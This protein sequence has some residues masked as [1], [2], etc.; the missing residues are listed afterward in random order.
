M[1]EADLPDTGATGRTRAYAH[2]VDGRPPA[3]WHDLREHLDAV[4]ARAGRFADAFG[5]GEWGRLAGLWHDLGKYR[6][7]FQAYL[8]GHGS[9]GDHAVAGA[10]LAERSKR[11]GDGWLPLAFAIAGHHVGL[12]DLRP[13]DDGSPPTPLVDRLAEKRSTLDEAVARA[14]ADLVAA[15]LPELPPRFRTGRRSDP[16]A[17]HRSLRALALWIRFVF[18][19]LVDADFLDTERF[20]RGGERAGHTGGFAAVP[21]LRQRLDRHLDALAARAPASEVNRVRAEVLAAARAAAEREPG[22]FSM[23]V[24]TG[25]GKTLASMS[26][27]LR[28]A[29]RH[30]LRRV[31]V[32]IPL[33][34]IIEQSAAV[35]RRALGDDQVI[36]HHSNLDPAKE[37]RR[38]KLASENWD[39]PVIVTTAVQL[40]ESLFANRTSRCRKLHNLAGSVIVLDEAQTLPPGLLAPIL[41]VLDELS[42]HYRCSIVLSTATQPALARREAL[43]QGLDGVREMMPDPTALA[44]RLVRFR[45]EWR[46]PVEWDQLAAELAEHHRVLTIVHKRRDARELAERLPGEHTFHLS[47]LMCAAHRLDV[48]GRLRD[49]LVD[50]ARPCRLVSTQLVEAGVDISFPVVYRALAGIDSLLQA[51]GRCNRE[52]EVTLGRLIVFEAPTE[53]PPGVPRK[54]KETTERMLAQHGESLDLFSPDTIEEYFRSLYQKHHLDEHDVLRALADLRFATVARRFRLIEDGYT[55]PLVVPYGEAETR[56]ERLRR[57]GPSRERL[58]ALQPFVVNVPRRDLQELAALGAVEVIHEAVF[59]LTTAY[60]RLYDGDYGFAWTSGSPPPVADV[61]FA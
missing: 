25:G 11:H 24:P 45:P 51:G 15:A 20:Y 49:T 58:R 19:A 39:A 33:T 7:G 37:T 46:G 16:A 57:D 55:E 28:H 40:F 42:G 60:R 3:E 10:L 34:S 6:P 8:H 48:L 26:F 56:L 1:P 30:G 5:A 61:L 53:P 29:E 4:A 14:P 59:A 18:S 41:E 13:S 54:G 38:N 23:S 9:G 17:L 32:A 12:A 47:A 52:G 27:A 2:T 22:L 44:R 21:L 36:E 50:P 31:V 43:P 35:Y